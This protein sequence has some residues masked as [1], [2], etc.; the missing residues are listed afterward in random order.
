MTNALELARSTLLMAGVRASADPRDVNAPGAWLAVESITHAKTMCGGTTTRVAIY[1]VAPNVGV[2]QAM[3]TLDG[4]L[5]NVLTVLEPDA[6]STPT[7]LSLPDGSE[8]PALKLTI[9]VS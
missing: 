7:T 2:T 6:P 5:E 3:S 8:L 9:D 4:M 1:L